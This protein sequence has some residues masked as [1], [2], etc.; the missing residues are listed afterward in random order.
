MFGPQ[1]CSEER[2]S[3]AQPAVRPSLL[4]TATTPPSTSSA[5]PTPAN[6]ISTVACTPGSLTT[7]PPSS[8]STPS[9]PSSLSDPPLTEAADY[10]G[11][12]FLANINLNNVTVKWTLKADNVTRSYDLPAWSV[13][14]VD[15]ATGAVSFNTAAGPFV[16]GEGRSA[17]GSR[18]VRA[19]QQRPVVAAVGDAAFKCY[20]DVFGVWDVSRAQKS[21]PALE[22]VA[23]TRGQ[24]GRRASHQCHHPNPSAPPDTLS[25]L[26]LSAPLLS[27]PTTCSTPPL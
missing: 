8:A 10:G 1:W 22:Q 5:S 24:V 3:A 18:H 25:P 20:A 12:V 21:S 14:F 11:V 13:S 16:E 2:T 15:G 23:A 27:A 7:P 19:V 6:S 9:L 26:S 4:R 17:R